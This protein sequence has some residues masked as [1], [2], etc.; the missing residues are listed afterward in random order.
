MGGDG[1]FN[2]FW[3]NFLFLSWFS[4]LSCLIPSSL[5]ASSSCLGDLLQCHVLDHSYRH[6]VVHV[7]GRSNPKI[8]KAKK[9]RGKRG[10]DV[11][12]DTTHSEEEGSRCMPPIYVSTL[13]EELDHVINRKRGG[14]RIERGGRRRDK[15]EGILCWGAH[16]ICKG[17]EEVYQ[18]ATGEYTAM[19]MV[20][21]DAWRDEFFYS[22]G[23]IPFLMSFNVKFL[24]QN[25]K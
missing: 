13:L 17:C 21:D 14:K 4:L 16:R 22:P 19:T 11:Y 10:E 18:S 20:E 12:N 24:L 6:R 25:K 7:F 15:G 9:R 8:R 5:L 23:T 1:G 3:S 2:L